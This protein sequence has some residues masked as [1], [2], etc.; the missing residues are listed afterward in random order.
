MPVIFQRLS[1]HLVERIY[2]RATTISRAVIYYFLVFVARFLKRRTVIA[3]AVLFLSESIWENPTG[4]TYSLEN[5]H[6][7]DNV[8]PELQFR[9]IYYTG[10]QN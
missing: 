1:S 5:Y 10:Q 2:S 8:I 3:V 9:I 7:Y 6:T 4:I